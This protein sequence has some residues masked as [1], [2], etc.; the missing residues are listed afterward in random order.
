MITSKFTIGQHVR[1]R[2]LGCLGVIVDVDAEY[3]LNRPSF[4]DVAINDSLRMA[5]WYHVVVEDENGKPVHTYLAEAQLDAELQHELI[6]HTSLDE[7]AESIKNE[8][9]CPRLRN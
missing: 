1:H 3:S 7:I 9:R 5:P 6:E 8:L 4:D 2:L